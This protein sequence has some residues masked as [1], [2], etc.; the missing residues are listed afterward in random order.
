M[1][2]RLAP[3]A[4]LTLPVQAFH[5]EKTASASCASAE[6]VRQEDFTEYND[7]ADAGR[8]GRQVPPRGQANLPFRRPGAGAA[9]DVAARTRSRGWPQ[10]RRLHLGLPR[11]AAWH[12]RPYAVACEILPASA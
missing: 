7:D 1:P 9:T 11:L 12:V 6:A 10:H 8:A 4:I 5:T 3:P 2:A